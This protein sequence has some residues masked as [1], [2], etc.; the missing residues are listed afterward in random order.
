MQARGSVSASAAA[1][2]F[3]PGIAEGLASETVRDLVRAD[4]RFWIDDIYDQRARTSSRT[5]SG[6]R[7]MTTSESGSNVS[8]L[9][10][11]IK[12]LGVGI[13]GATATYLSQVWGA[14][15][16]VSLTLAGFDVYSGATN[17][18]AGILRAGSPIAFSPNSA[19]IVTSALDLKGL[20][21]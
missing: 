13:T 1:G 9:R 5:I 15:T 18:V 12:S 17:V 21:T 16:D 20:I 3:V 2:V 19:F 6:L 11:I 4:V 8:I 10:V 7:Y 14:I